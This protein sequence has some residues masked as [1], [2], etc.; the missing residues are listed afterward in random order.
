MECH[1]CQNLDKY[2]LLPAVPCIIS[3]GAWNN[4]SMKDQAGKT[5]MGHKMKHPM[6]N[7]PGYNIAC[8]EDPN[9]ENIFG[10]T[11]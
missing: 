8:K 7:N 1:Y 4:S 10:P 5:L 3:N 9:Y 6:I 11:P 2:A